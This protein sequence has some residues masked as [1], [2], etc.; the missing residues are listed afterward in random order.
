MSLRNISSLTELKAER[1]RLQAEQQRAILGIKGNVRTEKLAIQRAFDDRTQRLR[2]G[3][4]DVESGTTKFWDKYKLP[5][6]GGL[7]AALGVLLTAIL[8]GGSEAEETQQDTPEP[9]FDPATE[10]ATNFEHHEDGPDRFDRQAPL[11]E[12]IKAALAS[13]E[14]EKEEPRESALGAA[15]GVIFPLLL[16]ELMKTDFVQ[17]ILHGAK[18]RAADEWDKINHDLADRL[19]HLKEES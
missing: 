8:T 15:I 2:Q 7:G 6:L 4:A 3:F 12:R 18:D 16:R 19:E 13:Y 17:G 5:A 11:E 9:I 1:E 14:S 10:Q